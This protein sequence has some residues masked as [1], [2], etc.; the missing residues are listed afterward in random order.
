MFD[1]KYDLR[2]SIVILFVQLNTRE[3]QNDA[4]DALE[5]RIDELL[6]RQRDDE[7]SWFL[8]SVA[9][10]FCDAAHR[11]RVSKLLTDRAKKVNGAQMQVTRGLE[12][13]DQCIAA[14]ARDMPGLRRFFSK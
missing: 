12:M 7:N 4:F 3:T 2:E 10:A 1:T 9:G 8:G 5:K 11:D 6:A 14:V 13:T